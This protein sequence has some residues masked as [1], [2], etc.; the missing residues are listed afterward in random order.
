MLFGTNVVPVGIVSFTFTVV[1]A[2]PFVF[3][4]SIVYVISSPTSTSV[5]FA[6]DDSFLYSTNGLFTVVF[7]VFVLLSSTDAVLV[8]VFVTSPCG[9]SFTVTSNETVVCP[10]FGTFTVIPFV[11]LS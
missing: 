7:T 2:V 3:F 6:G 11:R 5:L 1:G 9:N 8:I 4:N 10:L